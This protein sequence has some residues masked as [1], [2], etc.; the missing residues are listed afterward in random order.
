MIH[1]LRH[2]LSTLLLSASAFGGC[3]AAQSVEAPPPGGLQMR[4]NAQ[5]LPEPSTGAP[6]LPTL[7]NQAATPNLPANPSGGFLFVTFKGEATPL[8]EQI[9]FALSSDGRNWKALNGTE[10]VLVS[11]MGEKGVRD[12]FL[13]RSPDG[14]KFYLLA[15]DLSINLNRNWTRAV[16]EGSKSIVIWESDDLVKWSAPRLVPVAAAD[17]GCTWAP[18]AI[19]DEENKDYLV[20]WA[21]TNAADNFAKQKIWASRTKDFVNFG[22][23]FVYIERPEAV[24]DTDIVRDNGKYFRFSKDEKNKGITVE[25]SEKLMGPWQDM[26]GSSLAKLRGYEGPA[27][28]VLEPA[29]PGKPATWCVLLDY[30]SRGQGYQPFVTQDLAGG[31]FTPVTDFSFPFRLRHGSVVPVSAAEYARLNAAWGEKVAPK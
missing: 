9:Y 23:P 12:P 6:T 11:Q 26:P 15:T 28:F 1:F 8:T 25:S 13:V 4:V 17:A 21:S 18:E 24:I 2:P 3:A 27:G 31:Q 10:P 30:Y 7:P 14:K 19:Y 5:Q 22:A 29:A 20:F 16:R